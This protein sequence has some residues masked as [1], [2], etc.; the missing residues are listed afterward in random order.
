[1]PMHL[2]G[3]KPAGASL[4]DA[5][6]Q[7]VFLTFAGGDLALVRSVTG[8]LAAGRAITFD[9]AL[10]SEPFDGVRGDIIRASLL[11]RLRHCAAALCLYGPNT[12]D[13]LWVRW[14]LE[15]AAGLRLPL[16]GAAL[17]G[18]AST[19]AERLL[20]RL[21]AEIVPLERDHV[22]S[23]TRSLALRQ[24]RPALDAMSFAETLQLMRHPLR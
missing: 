2:R 4:R 7:R 12:A 10:T 8:G 18:G 13:D 3:E 22:V 20:T 5:T 11:I 16:L 24:D 14:A 15:V 23:A 9:Q 1:M 19:D 6:P 17:P 21:G